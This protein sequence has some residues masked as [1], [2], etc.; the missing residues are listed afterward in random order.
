MN[1]YDLARMAYGDPG[2]FD[3]LAPVGQAF[4]SAAPILSG[5]ASFVPIVGPLISRGIDAAAGLVPPIEGGPTDKR[6]EDSGDYD[7]YDQGWQGV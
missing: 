7:E 2:F 5:I 6:D 3:F 1:S 4:K